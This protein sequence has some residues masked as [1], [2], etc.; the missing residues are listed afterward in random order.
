MWE[1]ELTF[2]VLIGA[3]ILYELYGRTALE[4][5]STYAMWIRIAGGCAVIA[6]FYW[7]A[8]EAPD[9]FKETLNLAKG[10][11]IHQGQ[12]TTQGTTEGATGTK[13]K[14]N[15]SAL[16]KKKIAAAQQWKCGACSGLLDETYEVDHKLALFQG[17]T[18]EPENLVALCPNC[19]RK[20]TVEER[21]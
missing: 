11:L 4:W 20:K 13:E 1:V 14:R 15:V 12:G 6:F 2:A 18:N 10:L 19:H 5:L 7:Q 21:L 9:A 16:L 3:W 17:G 8:R